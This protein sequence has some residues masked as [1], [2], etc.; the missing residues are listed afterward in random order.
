[1]VD[2]LGAQHVN[3]KLAQHLIE[4]FKKR[5]EISTDWDGKIYLGLEI[6]WNY[7]STS[8]HATIE[9][10]KHTP[11]ALTKLKHLHPRKTHH[12]LAKQDIPTH[13]AKA[14]RAKIEDHSESILPPSDTEDI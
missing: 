5:H 13:G 3:V 1:M 14:Q 9:M 10:P 4:A 12:N 11:S 8:K 6:D 7:N 2:D